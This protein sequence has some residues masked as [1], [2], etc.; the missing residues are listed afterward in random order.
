MYEKEVIERGEQAIRD[1]LDRV[2]FLKIREIK[3]EPELS[4]RRPDFLVLVEVANGQYNLVVEARSSGQQIGRASC[5]E[6][7]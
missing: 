2:P 5:R 3:I 7:V 6:R 4:G 1:C